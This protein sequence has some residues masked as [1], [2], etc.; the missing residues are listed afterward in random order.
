ML[1][2]IVQLLVTASRV[3][4]KQYD[5]KSYI[6]QI[7]SN[8]PE[9][10]WRISVRMFARVRFRCIRVFPQLVYRPLPER[11]ADDRQ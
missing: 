11:I 5:N 9:R 2:Y 4:V 7:Q 3:Y 1:K 6:H 10:S 8:F